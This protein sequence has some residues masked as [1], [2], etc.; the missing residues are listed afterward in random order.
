MGA[1]GSSEM[2]ARTY[3]MTLHIPEDNYLHTNGHENLKYHNRQKNHYAIGQ[4]PQQ[5]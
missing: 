3:H 5:F 1:V 2:S 4:Y